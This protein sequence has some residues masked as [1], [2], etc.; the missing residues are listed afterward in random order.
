MRSEPLKN[1]LSVDVEDYFHAEALAHA[2]LRSNWN[3]FECRVEANTRRLLDLFNERN[4][5]ATF[6]WWAGLQNDFLH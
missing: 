2:A 6:S 1:V 3:G 5:R 4:V